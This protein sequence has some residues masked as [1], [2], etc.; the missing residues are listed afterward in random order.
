MSIK[1]KKTLSSIIFLAIIAFFVF[2]IRG[3]WSEFSQIKVVS[4]WA[5]IGAL[6][7]VPL[8]FYIQGLI[9]KIVVQPFGIDLKFREYF[10]LLAVTLMGNFLIPFSGL[11]F[12]GIYLKKVYKFSYAD[13]MTTLIAVW[14]INFLIYSPGGLIGLI[15]LKYRL[16]IFDWRLA[17]IFLGV[18]AISILAL[19]PLKLTK[20]KNR[21]VAFINQALGRWQKFQTPTLIQN[22]VYLT[23]IQFFITALI[24]YLCYRIYG[25][26]INFM[27]TFL[28]NSLGLYSFFIRLVPGNLGIFELAVVYPS[29][30][31]GLS[32]AQGLSV[33]A[34]NRLVNLVWTFAL[35]LIFSYILVRPTNKEKK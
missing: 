1:L 13:F 32:A 11:G 17:T 19:F 29:K 27:D 34:A 7:L 25:F 30:V 31:L 8:S 9:I 28:P 18:W 22:L 33:S 24:F 26:K 10:G 16:G 3:H 12:R 21:L 23:I 35:G 5:L 14:V 4:W 6:L 20:I 2:Y 15:F